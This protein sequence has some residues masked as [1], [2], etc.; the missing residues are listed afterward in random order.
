[1][2]KNDVHT[3][4]GADA[5]IQGNV[6]CQGGVAVYGRVFGDVISEGP[7]RIARGGEVHG[8]VQANDAQIGGT[9]DGNIRVENRVVLGA[10][11]VLKG[12]LAYRTLVIEEGAEF[13]GHC[14]LVENDDSTKKSVKKK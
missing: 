1:M 8:N 14:V 5:V 9:I 13:Q 6:T 7:V 3:M 12:D 2:A 11:C 4:V 10:E